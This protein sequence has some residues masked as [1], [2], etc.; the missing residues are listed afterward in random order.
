MHGRVAITLLLALTIPM[1]SGCIGVDNMH[2]LRS[3]LRDRPDVVTVPAEPANVAPVALIEAPQ[4]TVRLGEVLVLDATASRDPDG[5][6]ARWTW[7]VDGR[8][9]GS[10]STLAHSFEETGAHTVRLVV[11]DDEGATGATSLDVSVRRDRP[12][13]ANMSLRDGDGDP[14]DRAVVDQSLVLSGDGSLDPEG[15]GLSYAWRLGDGTRSS[16]IVVHHRYQRGGRYEVRLVVTDP[17]GQTAN[18]TRT[19][20]VDDGG[21]TAGTVTW[22]A[23]TV[24]V[25]LP[26]QAQARHVLVEVTYRADVPGEDIDLVLDGPGGASVSADGQEGPL[27]GQRLVAVDLDDPV[28]GTWTARTRLDVGLEADFDLTWTVTY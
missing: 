26:V 13:R 8:P 16:Q 20:A 23:P 25:D 15:D 11:E 4:T 28:A 7:T 10:S 21:T 14:V 9:A 5:D 3:Q 24:E 19:L 1:L 27:P 18:A 22:D 6:L 17:A 12:P 2:E